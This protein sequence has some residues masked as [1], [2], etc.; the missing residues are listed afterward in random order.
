MRPKDISFEESHGDL[1]RSSLEQILD[2]KHPLYVMANRID[3]E[4]FD[5]SFGE[6]RWSGFLG[7]GTVLY[8]WEDA[9]G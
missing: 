5:K 8:K 7:Q 1:F 2:R 4:R 3:W 9:L 6:L